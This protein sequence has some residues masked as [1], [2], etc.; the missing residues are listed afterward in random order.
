MRYSGTSY[1]KNISGV[2]PFAKK[3]EPLRKS[4]PYEI[5]QTIF[6]REGIAES[7]VMGVYLFRLYY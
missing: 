3:L 2:N 1:T 6:D 5:A 7:Q 4:Q